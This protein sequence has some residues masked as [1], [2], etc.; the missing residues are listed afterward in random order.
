MITVSDYYQH[1]LKGIAKANYRNKKILEESLEEFRIALS[2]KKTEEAYSWY[3]N[4]AYKLNDFDLFIK[5]MAEGINHGFTK[6]YISL[7][8]FYATNISKGDKEKAIH[9]FKKRIES[10]DLV[11]LEDLADYYFYGTK[12]FSRDLD[13]ASKLYALLLFQSKDPNVRDRAAYKIGVIHL[14][15]REI[16]EALE[17]F[18]SASAHN[19]NAC[20]EIGMMYLDGDGVERDTDKAI[21]YFLKA[22]TNPNPKMYY[23]LG[24]IFLHEKFG[25]DDKQTALAYFEMGARN[26]EPESAFMAACTLH[27]LNEVTNREKKLR[28]LEIAFKYSKDNPELISMLEG[29]SDFF[30]PDYEKEINE[31]INKYLGYEKGL[32]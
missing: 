6:L 24:A 21:E 15:K 22:P 11:S 8:R 28:Y 3:G 20:Y 2:I 9:C 25:I 12:V 16:K 19:S 4:V 1:L 10:G 7:G 26:Y 32:A 14:K 30:G 18:E 17:L 23:Q 5:I 29:V 27:N 31:M 13:E